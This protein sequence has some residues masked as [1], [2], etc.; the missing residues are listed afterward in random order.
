M[1]Q[2]CDAPILFTEMCWQSR[3]VPKPI[4]WT[5]GS[6]RGYI[7]VQFSNR[8]C[9]DYK[10]N[11]CF[12]SY[13]WIIPNSHATWQWSSSWSTIVNCVLQSYSVR[14][15][16][17][18][19]VGALSKLLIP[20]HHQGNRNS[21]QVRETWYPWVQ[22]ENA[23]NWWPPNNH[24]TLFLLFGQKP[25]SEGSQEPMQIFLHLQ[26][27]EFAEGL[28]CLHRKCQE[29]TVLNLDEEVFRI[30]LL[31]ILK[32]FIVLSFLFFFFN[33][34][35]SDHKIASVCNTDPGS[36]MNDRWD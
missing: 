30:P 1:L 24:G 31:L 13:M 29:S 3:E 32:Q 15:S 22:V 2:L 6:L 14:A 9:Q 23:N 17:L 20:R 33:Q 4:K 25:N 21:L 27:G 18:A 26:T 16:H 19:K 36:P 7:H 28:K 5:L 34:G 35:S 11:I 10:F 8:C 12:C